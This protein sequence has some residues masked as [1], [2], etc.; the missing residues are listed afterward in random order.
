MLSAGDRWLLAS[1]NL[2]ADESEKTRQEREALAEA[3][4]AGS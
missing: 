2:V 4:R 3:I 1:L